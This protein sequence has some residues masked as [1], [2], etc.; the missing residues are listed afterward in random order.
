MYSVLTECVSSFRARMSRLAK[1]Q[2]QC[3]QVWHACKSPVC[4]PPH[5]EGAGVAT[6][7]K[8]QITS[9]QRQRPPRWAWM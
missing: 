8:G 9:P 1:Q 7:A 4:E 6:P 2:P 3:P 5:G